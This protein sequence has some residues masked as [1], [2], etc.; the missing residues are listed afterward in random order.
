MTEIAD[1]PGI[2]VVVGATGAMGAAFTQRLVGH[3]IRVIA[4]ARGEEALASLAS[5]S[6]LIVPCV[7]DIGDNASI[8]VIAAASAGPVRMA[9]FAA[10]LPVRGGAET[11]DPDLFG[12]GAN[13]KIG[14]MARLVQAVRPELRRGSRVVAV[15]GSLGLEPSASE[16][17]PGA[18]NAGLFN[19]MRQYSLIFGPLGITTHTLSP[20]PTDTPRLRRIV[21]AVAEERGAS[22][23]E[24][25]AEYEARNSLGRLPTIE[26]IAWS[27]DML[28]A[29]Q[30]DLMHGSVIKLDG[31]ATRGIG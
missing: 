5:S 3:G 29:P 21:T 2:A 16:A 10:G 18:I 31:G 15:A 28:L 27:I 20:G 26:E 19:L 23:D 14:G 12:I 6:E 25:W 17:G 7:A 9:L 4:V 11:I 22:F 8:Q 13:I 30:A 24:V 1:I